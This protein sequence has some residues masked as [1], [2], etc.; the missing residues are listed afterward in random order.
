MISGAQTMPLILI[1]LYGAVLFALIHVSRKARR[2][3]NSD[4]CAYQPLL[5]SSNHN[6]NQRALK[7][8]NDPF[9]AELGIAIS[10]LYDIDLAAGSY[11]AEGC[12]W[13]KYREVPLWMRDEWDSEI[14]ACPIKSISFVNVVNRQDFQQSLAPIMP[15]TDDD[16]RMIHWLEF[17]GRFVASEIDLDL[18]MFPFE[19]IVLPIDFELGDFYVGEASISHQQSGPVLIAPP[20]IN[21]YSCIGSSVC[22]C[23]H[24]YPTNWGHEYARNYFGKDNYAEYIAFKVEAVFRRNTWNSFFNVFLPLVIIMV[25][26][27]ATPLVA[28][29][30][31]QTKLAIPASALLVLVFLQD[32]YKKILP[33]GLN[34]PTLADLIY[35]YNMMITIIV[36]LWSLIQT[37]LFFVSQLVGEDSNYVAAAG[38]QGNQFFIITIAFALVAPC[39]FYFSSKHFSPVVY[40]KRDRSSL[41]S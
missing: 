37:K 30:D 3:P 41:S 21:G 6:L 10:T 33:P 40:Q 20:K 14:F 34:Y 27:V 16:G 5:E 15:D 28:I 7:I 8:K 26:V 12:A 32:G 36:F 29:Q 11:Y 35:I 39:L 19:T 9:T 17:T 4:S 13:L 18:R 38:M 1:A 24:V 2:K 31:Y 23:M 22:P 25:V